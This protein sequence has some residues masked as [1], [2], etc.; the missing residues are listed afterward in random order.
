MVNSVFLLLMFYFFFV[1]GG[2]ERGVMRVKVVLELEY[3]RVS[4]NVGWI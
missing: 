2:I 4:I 3:F 1:W